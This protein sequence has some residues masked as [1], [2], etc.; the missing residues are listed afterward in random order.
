[1]F[2]G[3]IKPS[4]MT[5]PAFAAA[6]EAR[7]RLSLH[8][9]LH[10][11]RRPPGLPG[12][13]PDGGG[14]RFLAV[15]FQRGAKRH[16]GKTARHPPSPAMSNSAS[17]RRCCENGVRLG[18]ARRRLSPWC[19]FSCRGVPGSPAASS[20]RRIARIFSRCSMICATGRA[21]RPG[22]SGTKSGYHYEGPTAGVGATQ[23]W[24]SRGHSGRAAREAKPGARSGSP[25]P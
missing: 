3:E 13:R 12:L 9:R 6:S 25:T 2:S 24:S 21:G 23:H 22:T 16:Y 20:S 19:R 7:R 10:S 8:R 4:K 18:L 15:A 17:K 11:G 5:A 14:D 1:M